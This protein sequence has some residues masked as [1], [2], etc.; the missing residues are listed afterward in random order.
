MFK[1]LLTGILSLVLL[2]SGA[3]AVN[4]LAG[5]S[6]TPGNAPQM[7]PA[8]LFQ[9]D[10]IA[11][12]GLGCSNG[13]G[14][15]G[16]PNDVVQ[17]VAAASAPPFNI[18]GHFY[19]IY[20]QVSPTITALSF[21]V[22][23]G[24]AMPGAEI[25]RVGGLDWSMGSHTVPISPH[26]PVP[27]AFLF[28]GHN[29]PQSNVGMRWGLDTSTGGA[30]TSYIRAPACGATVFT[31]IDQLGFPGN[32]VMSVTINDDVVPVELQSWGSTKAMFR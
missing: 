13:V 29:Q 21:I 25:G 9:G 31:L 14:T 11:E 8:T 20:T 27:T 1:G 7:R 23:T 32:W 4:T 16:G 18:T 19:Y 3:A 28:F 17:G 26:V 12:M 15:S 5:Y 2:A 10:L 22:H 6:G 24:M 30:G